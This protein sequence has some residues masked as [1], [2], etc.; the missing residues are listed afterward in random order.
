MEKEGLQWS[1]GLLTLTVQGE[2]NSVHGKQMDQ[3][4]K[5]EENQGFCIP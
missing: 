1:L 3:K 5:E 2:E 4:E